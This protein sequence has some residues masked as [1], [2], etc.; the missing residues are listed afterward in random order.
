MKA[1]LSN[2]GELWPSTVNMA[3]R[4]RLPPWSRY[5]PIP[6]E[7]LLRSVSVNAENVRVPRY[8]TTASNNSRV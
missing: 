8:Q 1:W 2:P 3:S 7:C 5:A 4:Y 6:S